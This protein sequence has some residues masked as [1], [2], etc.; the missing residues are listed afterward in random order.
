MNKREA[1]MHRAEELVTKVARSMKLEGVAYEFLCWPEIPAEPV[2]AG[3]PNEATLPL[4]V[5]KGNSWR[6]IGFAGSDIDGSVDNP[7]LLNKYE[8]EVVQCLSEL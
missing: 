3:R 1:G 7:E 8:S 6:S 5:Y 4:R 2:G